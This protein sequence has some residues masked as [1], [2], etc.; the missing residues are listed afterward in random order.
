MRDIEVKRATSFPGVPTM[1]IAIASTARSRQARPVVAGQLRLRRRAAAGRSGQDLRAQGRHEA[2]ERLGHDRDLLARHRHP[3][4]GPE[5]P[6]SIGLMLPGIEMDV[7]A[8][9]DPD[10]DSAGRRNRRNP[11]PRPERHQGL[12]EPA[13]GDRRGFR[14]RPLSHRRYRLHGR[15]RLFLP[16]RPQEGHDHLRR[17]QRLSAD[18]RAGDLRAS[19]RARGDRDRHSRRLSRRGGQGFCQIARRRCAVQPGR[20][21]R[22]S[23]PA[24]SASTKFPRRSNSSTNCRA[25][26][27][28]SSRATNCATGSRRGQKPQL[29]TG[30]GHDTPSSSLRTRTHTRGALGV[31][32][33]NLSLI[34]G[35]WVPRSRGRR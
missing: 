23:S 21:A 2:E 8:L 25:P 20:T 30:G 12:L 5:K 15:R 13:G 16:G 29:A 28:A 32:S 22:R 18:D 4:E 27:S 3:K 26:R 31:G 1:W 14:R 11:H 19:R 9:D 24:S 7:V 17:L 33:R 6:G 10:E 35:L 34:P